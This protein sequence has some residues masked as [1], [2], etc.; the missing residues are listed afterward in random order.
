[1]TT[2]DH[3]PH[4]ET[5]NNHEPYPQLMAALGGI[6]V[7]LAYTQPTN[8]TERTNQ[9][10]FELTPPESR[11]YNSD[12]PYRFLVHVPLGNIEGRMSEIGTD[13]GNDVLMAS[14]VTTNHQG[15]FKGRGGIIVDQPKFESVIGT[16]AEDV[17]SKIPAGRFADIDSLVAPAAPFTYNQIDMNFN[18]T[19][20]IG[21]LIKQTAD[22]RE[23]GDK[24]S[25]Q[26]LRQYAEQHNLPIVTVD[27]NP[28]TMPTEIA[29][30]HTDF[31]NNTGSL[32]TIT[33]PYSEDKHL[34]VDIRRI[35]NDA[36]AY[37]TDADRF[38]RVQ[39]INSYGEAGEAITE[40]Q[41]TA[42]IKELTKLVDESILSPEDV[43]AVKRDMLK[44]VEKVESANYDDS[45]EQADWDSP[46]RAQKLVEQYVTNGSKVLDLGIGT[47][48]AVKGYAEKGAAIIGLDRD[49]EMLELSRTVTGKA[50]TMRQ[51]DINEPLPIDDLAE[52]IDVAQA[53]GVLEFASDLNSVVNQ[54]KSSLKPNGV[55]V[56]TVET[57]DGDN[58]TMQEY[59]DAGVTV[60]RRAADTVKVLLEKNGL[61]LLSDEAYGGYVRGD[62]DGDKVPYHIFLAQK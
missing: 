24:N 19:T 10:N 12:E 50:G 4:T 53:I 5:N 8:H 15:T 57:P 20:P 6:S 13:R 14:L 33:L 31:P 22:G 52:Q 3:S 2:I 7:D 58:V 62:T 44:T 42:T 21:V 48:Q 39:P 11:T 54:V 40:A 26:A 35:G 56:F 49:P 1:M 51:A 18:G 46:K 29:I 36:P 41:A 47:G 32:D 27:V 55:F 61:Q 9:V 34:R 30:K 43:V 16:D 28:S 59:P 38:A 17:G 60:H 23:L 45:A 37:H 25:N